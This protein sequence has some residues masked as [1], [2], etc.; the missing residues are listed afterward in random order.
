[1]PE[2]LKSLHWIFSSYKWYRQWYGGR[3]E[4]WSIDFPVCGLCWLSRDTRKEDAMQPPVLGR[5][6]PII[7]VYP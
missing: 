5:S 1:M 6:T 3:W 7:E 4:R 2:W